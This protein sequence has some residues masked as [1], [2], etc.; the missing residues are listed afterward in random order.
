MLN[1]FRTWPVRVGWE[2]SVLILEILSKACLRHF[3][4]Y[5]M[6]VCPSHLGYKQDLDVNAA[7]TTLGMKNNCYVNEIVHATSNHIPTLSYL[8]LFI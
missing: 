4:V 5:G 6:P 1:V 3:V 7:Q 2:I 8:N